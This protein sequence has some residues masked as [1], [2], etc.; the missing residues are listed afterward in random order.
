MIT[1]DIMKKLNILTASAKYDVACTSS[2]VTRQNGK[3]GM[4]IQFMPEYVTAFQVTD[5][6]YPYLKFCILMNVYMTAS[7]ASTDVLTM[8]NVLPSHLRSLPGLP[9]HFINVTI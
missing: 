4:V 6:V 9:Y 7:I 3:S 5:D 2:G 8:L 1:E